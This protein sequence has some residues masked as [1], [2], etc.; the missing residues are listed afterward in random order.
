LVD[1]AGDVALEAADD[2]AFGEAFGCASNLRGNGGILHRAR[3][4][5]RWPRALA[6]D[7]VLSAAARR[8]LFTPH[9]H[10][11]RARTSGTPTHLE[12]IELDVTRASWLVRER[13]VN[14]CADLLESALD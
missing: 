14:R 9:T 3:D 12:D 6:G 10:G 8:K 5:V 13:P 1:L 7:P 4:M 11:P 2:L